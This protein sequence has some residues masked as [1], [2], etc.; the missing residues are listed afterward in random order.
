MSPHFL[1]QRQHA[2]REAHASN[3]IE[4]MDMG[5]E[6]L[7]AL[8]DLAQQN[9]SNQEFERLAIARLKQQY[10]ADV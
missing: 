8:L 5:G 2:L 9:I 7:A 3:L 4:Q 10:C 6:R 1:Q